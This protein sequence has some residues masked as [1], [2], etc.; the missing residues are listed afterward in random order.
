MDIRQRPAG[1]T[2]IEVL[3]A[4]GVIATVSA[5]AI[6]RILEAVDEYTALGAVRY[7]STRLQKVR[8]EALTRHAN[9]AMRFVQVGESYQY[10]A[11][12]DGNGNGVAAADIVSG[13][14][15]KIQV[16]EQLSD[17]FA[18]VDFGTRPNLPAVDPG[19]PPPGADPI[20][21]GVSD[22]AAFTPLGT[23]TPG[24][25]YIIG[26]RGTQYVVRVLGETGKT[27]ILKFDANASQWK[28]L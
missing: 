13:V 19:S 4:L 12:A 28:P 21:F 18:H 24:S 15:P 27:R 1:Y 26:R 23:A 8:L 6:P 7:M 2:L 22:S 9:V 10:A 14:D 20:R 5:A 3:F 17:Q 11:Y 16:E 25:L